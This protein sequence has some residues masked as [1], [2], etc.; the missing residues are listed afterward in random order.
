MRRVECPTHWLN[1]GPNGPEWL[2]R[3]VRFGA[4]WFV[5]VRFCT[6]LPQFEEAKGV[7]IGLMY[8]DTLP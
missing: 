1:S 2:F 4:I 8:P 5:L 6:G 7:L 3:T